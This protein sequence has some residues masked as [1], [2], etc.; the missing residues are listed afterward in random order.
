MILVKRVVEADQNQG[1][2]ESWRNAWSWRADELF[3]ILEDDN[4]VFKNIDQQNLPTTLLLGVSPLVPLADQHVAILW[5][6]R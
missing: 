6:E 3:V 4:D 2:L 1:A 5:R